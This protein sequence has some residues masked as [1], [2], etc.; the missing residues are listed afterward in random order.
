M[1]QER[2]VDKKGDKQYIP[3]TFW[4]DREWRRLEPEESLPIYNQEALETASTV[5]IHEGPKSVRDLMKVLKKG[6]HPWQDELEDAAHIGWIGGALNPHRTDWAAL[7]KSGV[8]RAY[9]VADNDAPGL[10][11]I[12]HIAR[13]LRCITWSIQFNDDFPMGFDLGDTFPGRNVLWGLLCWS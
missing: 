11:A 13:S 6:N 3:W 5:F 9:I 10:S 8:T 7:A 12:K 2:I 1:V 4:S